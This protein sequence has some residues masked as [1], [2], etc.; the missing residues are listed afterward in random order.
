MPTT[1]YHVVHPRTFNIW[2]PWR[3]FLVDGDP[4]PGIELVKK[5]TKIYPLAA[6]GKPA[7]A[8]TYVNLSEKPFNMVTPAGY[9]FWEMLN[10]VVQEEP[11]DS[12]DPV[13]L[14]FFQSIGIQKGKH[15]A[16]DERM[17]KILTEVAAV[18][19]ATARA[20]AF[21][22]RDREAYY[23][24]QVNA[25]GSVDVYFGPK[26]PAGKQSNWVQTVP[27]HAWNTIFRLYGALEPFYAR[28]W[29]PGQI[30]PQP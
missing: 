29:R 16:P 22:T 2:L 3:S 9:A 19:D 21:H 13:T 12:L 25:D 6:A 24:V 17:K 4:K 15:F 11:S 23:Y 8:L 18:G 14:G 10:Q 26:A 30:E 7:P 5:H 28:T 1:G 20:N 27:G